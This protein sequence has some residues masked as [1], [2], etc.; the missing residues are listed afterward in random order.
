MNYAKIIDSDIVNGNGLRVSLFV[1]GCRRHCKGCFNEAA[2]AFDYGRLFDEEAL[3]KITHELDEPHMSGLSILGGEP[4]ELENL[5][6]VAWLCD[7]VKKFYP[8]KDIWVWTG[9]TFEALVAM[10]NHLVNRILNNIDVLVDGEFIEAEKD[11]ELKFRGSR[12]QRIID[13]VKTLA[14]NGD[15]ILWNDRPN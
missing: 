7:F 8:N 13:V 12:N 10:K 3:L 6:D 5:T 11:L 9:Y 1:S 14:G 4:F 2:Q 15:I